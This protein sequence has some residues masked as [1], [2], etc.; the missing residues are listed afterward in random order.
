MRIQNIIGFSEIGSRENAPTKCTLKVRQSKNEAKEV[1]AD[2]VQESEHKAATKLA[3][4]CTGMRSVYDAMYVQ[5][6]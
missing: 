5:V 6:K 2:P 3:A 4:L 1:A